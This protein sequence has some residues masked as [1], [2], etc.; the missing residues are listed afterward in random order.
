MIAEGHSGQVQVAHDLM[1]I[2][3]GPAQELERMVRRAMDFLQA[4]R[5]CAAPVESELTGT[6]FA[7]DGQTLFM[8]VQHP[9]EETKD[10]NNPTS[11]WPYRD[12]P[13]PSVVAISRQ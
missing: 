10:P 5:Y 3:V 12:I 1:R 2:D 11:R 9:G 6:W 8:A 7:H 4:E 13:R